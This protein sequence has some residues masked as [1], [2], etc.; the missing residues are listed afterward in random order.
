[1]FPSRDV[2]PTF[3]KENLSSQ[4]RSVIVNH[5]GIE[6]LSQQ[7]LRCPVPYRGIKPPPP[8]TWVLTGKRNDKRMQIVLC[9]RL[10]RLGIA[11]S[12]YH[13]L[14]TAV[15]DQYFTDIH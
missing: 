6:S 2:W 12:S 1:M 15:Y 11:L 7:K 13:Y 10:V 5:I 14:Y 3:F 9:S 8:L 4:L